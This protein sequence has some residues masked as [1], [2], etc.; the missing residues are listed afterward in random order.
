MGV[1]IPYCP[2]L[3]SQFSG[4]LNDAPRVESSYVFQLAVG[5]VGV[6]VGAEV[7]TI[8][9]SG[10]WGL[11][12]EFRIRNPLPPKKNISRITTARN[13]FPD[14]GDFVFTRGGVGAELLGGV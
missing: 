1:E 6:G 11:R 4:Y 9:A 7:G 8:F 2:E 13:N 3:I 12:R 14:K 5:S 10:G